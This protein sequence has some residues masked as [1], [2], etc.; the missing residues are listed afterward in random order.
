MSDPRVLP[1]VNQQDIIT[2][3]NAIELTTTYLRMARH[4][5]Q[6]LERNH[7]EDKV[8]ALPAD[9]RIEALTLTLSILEKEHSHLR[10]RALAE[11]YG[12]L[13]NYAHRYFV[14][15]PTISQYI[16]NRR[17]RDIVFQE[18]VNKD[19]DRIIALLPLTRG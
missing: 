2:I 5:K 15:V 9:E 3:K 18:T 13:K 14:T 6:D 11:H 1:K 8:Y 16:Y 17:K 12:G 4:Y 10:A 7:I 19:I